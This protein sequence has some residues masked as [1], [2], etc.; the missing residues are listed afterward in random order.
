MIVTHKARQAS[1]VIVQ[2]V[3]AVV[4]LEYQDAGATDARLATIA[5]HTALLVLVTDML[6]HAIN[7]LEPVISAGTTQTENSVRSKN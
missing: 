7:R 3:N 2:A 1:F 6:I 4:I 5:S